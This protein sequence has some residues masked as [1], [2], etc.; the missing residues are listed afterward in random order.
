MTSTPATKK[1]W[2]FCPYTGSLLSLDAVRNVAS[3]QQ[4]GYAI[5]LNELEDQVVVVHETDMEGYARQYGLEP[6]VKSEARVEE[7]AALQGRTRATVDEPCPKCG[8]QGLEFYTLQL[9][10]ADEGQ[11]VFYECPSCNHKYSQNN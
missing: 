9:R 8:H 4:S 11:T 7:E 3:S 5:S 10:S 1:D 2:M 6:L